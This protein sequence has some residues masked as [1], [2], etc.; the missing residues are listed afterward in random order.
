[1]MLAHATPS[2]RRRSPFARQLLP[3]ALGL[4]AA[5]P[6]LATNGMNLEAYGAKAGG[7][8]GAAFAY[9]SGN[10]AVMN[11]PA[12]LI[13]K[14]SGQGDFGLGLTLLAP[15]VSSNH[16]Q[17]GS[18]ASDATA[19]WMPTIG[20]MQRRGD[21]AYGVALLAQGGMGTEYGAGSSLFAG[22][23]SAA[24]NPVA[25]SGEDI[26]SELSFGRV[27]FPLAWQ[28]TDRLSL[29]GQVD[30]V[31]G[32]LD[33]RMDMDGQ[34]I[35]GMM[36]AGLVSGGLAG[37][38]G[39]LG[40]LHFARFDFSDHSAITGAAKGYG[41]AYKLG[42]LFKASDK[43]NLGVTY[44]S[45]T[46]I[47]DLKSDHA[48]IQADGSL[49]SASMNGTIR[50]VNFQ[51]P[52]TYG[53]GLA[54]TAN[55]Q[56]MWAADIKHIGWSSAMKNFQLSFTDA[57]SG[58]SL[59]VSMPQNWKDQTVYAIGAQYKPTP[60]LALRVG[61]NVASNPV[62]DNTLNPLFPAIVE[63]HYTAGIGY[64]LNRASSVD[65]AMTVAPEA[66]ATNPVTGITSNHSQMSL[67][68]NYSHAF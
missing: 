23:R 65:A 62:P 2:D 66:V 31:W 16:P 47:G 1:M 10:S 20:Y 7:M 4:L 55:E 46:Y 26:R 19:Y 3:A 48:R 39:G 18:V 40:D 52:E 41:T 15:D 60:A 50:V 11:N 32:G 67:R 14:P 53:I 6:T 68:V 59:N 43:L 17:A 57:G 38:L 21:L 56:W 45:R 9:D 58:Q 13:L 24:G 37:A 28:A 36:G 61:F 54:Y 5:G 27:M 44:H 42:A 25:L 63:R 33:L 22:G 12:T 51:W 35:A 30:L 29:A 8:G 34:T 64:R 49:G